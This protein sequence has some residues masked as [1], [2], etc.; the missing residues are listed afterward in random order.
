[1]IGPPAE[2]V[3]RRD[4]DVA[5]EPFPG[6]QTRALSANTDEVFVGGAKGCGKGD[7]LTAGNM[8]YSDR[9]LFAGLFLRET[10][11]ELKR[12]IDRAA[13]IYGKLSADRR[14]HWSGEL[15]RFTWPS[16]AF[17][18]YGHCRVPADFKKYQGGNWARISYDE[19]GNNAH[20]K[21]IRDMAL[22]EL[23][24]ADPTI[25]RQF[26]ASGNPGFAGHG[27]T[28]KL[29]VGPCGKKGERI[30]WERV[31]L[32]DGRVVNLSRSFIPGRVTDNPVYANDA[33]YMAQLMQLPERLRR[34]LL[35][36]DY[37]AASGL[38]LDEIE[39][40]A[41]LVKPFVCPSH[42]PYISGFDWGY[43]HWAV[44]MWGRVSDDGRVYICDTVK[45][46]LARDWDLA[47]TLNERAPAE[48]LQRVQAGHDNWGVDRSKAAS[49]NTPHRAA[50]FLECGIHLVQANIAR[51]LGYTN[52]LRYVGWRETE[53]LPQRVP[54]VQFMDTPTNRWLVEDH[55]PSMVNDP[56]DPSDVLKVDAHPETG[57]GG[58]D[59]YDCLRYLLASRPMKAESLSHLL[60]L[61]AWDPLVLAREAEKMRRADPTPPDPRA[62]RRG[63]Y[64]GV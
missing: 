24:C 7:I 64:T 63:H 41:H 54:M 59:G 13:T 20:A 19:L 26:V 47:G 62:R 61:S 31:Q 30:A 22:A 40:A 18:E 51:M 16:K 6:F 44:F 12:Q 60:K 50:Y 46:R 37:D 35:D 38:A 32:P 49:D 5:W 10:Y 8:R 42:W 33:T 53:Y 2:A 23:R 4:V 27:A 34:C 52:M 36:G 28:K 11:A 57:E 43:A 58:D 21:D 29:Y 3:T 45:R 25:R 55:L 48:A 39:P 56:D 17:V 14:P 1:M 15:Q 9:P